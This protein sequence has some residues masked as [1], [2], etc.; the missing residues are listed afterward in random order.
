MPNDGCSDR[1]V[2]GALAGLN[3]LDQ[4]R[5]AARRLMEAFPTSTL[6]P[7]R[8]INPRRNTAFGALPRGAAARGNSGM[9]AT[10]LGHGQLLEDR[11][12]EPAA[13][14]ATVS[15]PTPEVAAMPEP[16]IERLPAAS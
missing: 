2:I 7:Q 8:E 9:S 3:R 14:A 5:T 16:E 1:V 10:L 4:A 15:Q 11:A 12:P 13:E 6:T